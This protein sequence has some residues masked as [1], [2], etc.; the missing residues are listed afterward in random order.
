MREPCT[1]PDPPR[2]FNARNGPI[3]TRLLISSLPSSKVCG[4]GDRL[5]T[6]VSSLLIFVTAV[7]IDLFFSPYEGDH[8]FTVV[9][10]IASVSCGSRNSESEP[11]HVIYS[12][13]F[14]L[15]TAFPNAYIQRQQ[16]NR[17]SSSAWPQPQRQGVFGCRCYNILWKADPKAFGPIT[18]MPSTIPFCAQRNLSCNELL[19]K[20]TKYYSKEFS[21]FYHQKM[22]GIIKDSKVDSIMV[23]APAA[24]VFL[25]AK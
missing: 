2:A 18:R 3:C 20:G 17:E 7:S 10:A 21:R 8:K 13:M 19:R 12:Q 16:I 11:K 5:V 15:C 1:A 9:A 14:T 25:A 4:V 22:S 6:C 24:S 23:R